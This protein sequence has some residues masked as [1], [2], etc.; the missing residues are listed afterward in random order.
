MLLRILSQYLML[1]LHSVKVILKL[2]CTHVY[3]KIFSSSRSSP[4][5]IRIAAVFLLLHLWLDLGMCPCLNHELQPGVRMIGLSLSLIPS[6]VWA[7]QRVY[8]CPNKNQ[9]SDQKK[10]QF[11][12][13]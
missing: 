8:G 5:K 7:A 13:Q 3:K 9:G 2:S 12:V 6:T 10:G 11:L 1:V 4:K